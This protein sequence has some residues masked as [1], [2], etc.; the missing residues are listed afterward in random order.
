MSKAKD[1]KNVINRK[2]TLGVAELFTVFKN[3]RWNND[4]FENLF[5]TTTKLMEEVPTDLPIR[6]LSNKLVKESPVISYNKRI[7][8]LYKKNP[9]LTYKVEKK[10][11]RYSTIILPFAFATMYIMGSLAE[12][13]FN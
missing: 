4:E 3:L 1:I 6:E 11:S 8:T 10:K 12:L 5:A 7:H 9:K 2:G 13:V